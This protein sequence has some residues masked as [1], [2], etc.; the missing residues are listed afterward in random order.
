MTRCLHGHKVIL[1]YPCAV[2]LAGNPLLLSNTPMFLPNK[3]KYHLIQEALPE[4]QI[5]LGGPLL[6]SHPIMYWD[7]SGTFLGHYVYFRS[8]LLARACST[9]FPNM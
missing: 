1:S 4:P 9:M 8:H 5:G 7:E 2:P 6:F 3:L